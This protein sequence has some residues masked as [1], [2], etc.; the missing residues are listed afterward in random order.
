MIVSATLPGR[1]AVDGSGGPAQTPPPRPLLSPKGLKLQAR[2]NC[3]LGTELEVLRATRRDDG[4]EGLVGILG[5][6]QHVSKVTDLREQF[7]TSYNHEAREL[8]KF[9][10]K[11]VD[12]QKRHRPPS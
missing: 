12:V 7:V 3:Y 4:M 11:H 1:R 2:D 10:E 6:L 8:A 9:I 5:G